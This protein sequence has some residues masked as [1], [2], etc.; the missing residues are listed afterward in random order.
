MIDYVK[1]AFA[2]TATPATRAPIVRRCDAML[3][4]CELGCWPIETREH[5]VTVMYVRRHTSVP[6]QK[7]R[8]FRRLFGRM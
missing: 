1:F 4:F 5:S 6:L 7:T 8:E 3:T 2:E